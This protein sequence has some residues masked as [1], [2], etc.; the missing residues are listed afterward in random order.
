MRRT[1]VV[2]CILMLAIVLGVLALSRR[3]GD[4]KQTAPTTVNSSAKSVSSSLSSAA[5]E[6]KDETSSTN[7]PTA[8][9]DRARTADTNQGR[10]RKRPVKAPRACPD[11]HDTSA[12]SHTTPAPTGSRATEDARVPAQSPPPT[13]TAPRNT[14]SPV[15]RTASSFP[16]VSVATSLPPATTAYR[17][18]DE[19]REVERAIADEE[20]HPR[21]DLLAMYGRSSA[22]SGRFDMAAASYAMF[23]DEFGT[24]HPYSSR[25]AMRLADCLAP[26]NLDSINISHTARGP[27]YSPQWRMGY[28]SRPER[29]R[30]AIEAYDRAAELAG[31]MVV[32]GRALLRIG[33]IHRALHEWN[34]STAAWDRCAVEAA[35]TRS[36]A[37]ALW[38][39]AENLR[40]TGQPDQAA[41][42][43]RRLAADYPEDARIG[44]VA[45][46]LEHLEIEADRLP[47][48]L[49]DPVASLQAEIE[50]R[51]EVRTP[52]EVYRSVVRWLRRGEKRA[53][54]LDIG[55]WACGQDDWPIEARIGC[56]QDLVDALLVEPNDDARLEAVGRLGEIVDLASDDARMVQAAIR[57]YRLLGDLGQFHQA[58][59]V[60]EELTARVR[61]STR[62]EP[63]VLSEQIESLLARGDHDRARAVLDTLIASHPDHEV[64][65]RL[66]EALIEEDTEE[67]E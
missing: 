27:V 2:L 38:L 16:A 12:H 23:L 52:S 61:G 44:A 58:D 15:S 49:A 5:P 20:S 34:A 7:G 64:A 9:N 33:W 26:L 51:A 56:R 37:D 29:L 42:R 24:E 63:G 32:A 66:E 62:W 10:G 60:M 65:E 28:T 21:E 30:Q 48:W 18:E 13:G 54:L 59:Q 4:R 25:I 46:R 41:E 14:S 6:S 35:G 1:V 47:D 43:L 57:C 67:Q 17:F 3:A 36:A 19:R 45:Q 50:A 53:A 11:R 55:R 8:L 22:A 31:D 39:A 40:W